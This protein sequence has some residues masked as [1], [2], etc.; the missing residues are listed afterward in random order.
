[1]PAGEGGTVVGG[2]E[3]NAVR[4]GRSLH[5]VF[6]SVGAKL[7]VLY[8]RHHH[9]E[10][11]AGNVGTQHGALREQLVEHISRL[12]ERNPEIAGAVK[13]D[14]TLVVALS[15]YQVVVVVGRKLGL[16]HS[17]LP[18]PNRL[19]ISHILY[20]RFIASRG[21]RGVKS[22]TRNSRNTRSFFIN[23]IP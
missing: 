18:C 11:V 16:R 12:L 5:D 20:R 17:G 6:A 2:G 9:R 8:H 10:G 1:M 7:V 21:M 19:G 14:V 13:V 3:D 4:W 23:I 15:F 22:L